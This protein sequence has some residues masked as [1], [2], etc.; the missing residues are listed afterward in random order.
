[1]NGVTSMRR[2]DLLYLLL[3]LGFGSEMI[4]TWLRLQ[5][6]DGGW[7]SCPCGRYFYIFG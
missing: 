3:K 2:L 7:G 6:L 5:M 1:V 4:R